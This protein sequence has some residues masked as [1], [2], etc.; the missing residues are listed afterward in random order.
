MMSLIQKKYLF[1]QLG[2][3]QRCSG[4]LS[5]HLVYQSNTEC[6]ENQIPTRP[7]LIDGYET[8]EVNPEAVDW[9][10]FAC[11]PSGSLT[12]SILGEKAGT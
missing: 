4:K 12:T 2:K 1:S 7:T 9:E 5:T 6:L 11:C 3:P 8:E 10:S